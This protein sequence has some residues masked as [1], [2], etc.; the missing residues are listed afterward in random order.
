MEM[1]E[2]ATSQSDEKRRTFALE[3]DRHKHVL[4]LGHRCPVRRR[5]FAECL[6]WWLFDRTSQV[7]LTIQGEVQSAV[8]LWKDRACLLSGQCCWSL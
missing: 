1:M 2:R 7:V 6:F 8:Q 5:L 4:A 3:R